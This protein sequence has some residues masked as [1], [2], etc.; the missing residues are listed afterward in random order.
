MSFAVWRSSGVCTPREGRIVI[1]GSTPAGSGRNVV[2]AAEEFASTITAAEAAS[3]TGAAASAMRRGSATG[4][5]R[6]S[7]I[8]AQTTAS[9]PSSATLAAN[10][11]V[12]G[13]II[14]DASSPRVIA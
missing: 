5:M 9:A 6:S 7:S 1:G 11:V 4:T 13:A 10:S 14:T 8:A 2:A 3:A 12:V